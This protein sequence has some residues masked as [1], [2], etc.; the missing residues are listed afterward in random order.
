MGGIPR[1][2]HCCGSRGNP[3]RNVTGHWNGRLLPCVPP[4]N[5]S[6]ERVL[7]AGQSTLASGRFGSRERRVS[8]KSGSKKR[9]QGGGG[10]VVAALFA[11]IGASIL[12][13]VL[14]EIRFAHVGQQWPKVQATI[15][16]SRLESLG[17][18]SGYAPQ[19]L[20]KYK[21]QGHEY[22]SG[23]IFVGSRAGSK[24]WAQSFVTTYPVDKIVEAHFNPKRPSDSI[25]EPG[26]ISW[27]NVYGAIA[28]GSLFILSGIVILLVGMP[29]GRGLL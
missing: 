25:L 8:L 16:S 15:I 28:G 29:R 5:S 22:L 20:Y 24:N 18:K 4:N 23:R 19:V 12:I 10:Y 1:H 21:V 7:D 13:W 9:S 14:G 2:S 6:S 11:G 27:T 17:V 3:V 26:Q